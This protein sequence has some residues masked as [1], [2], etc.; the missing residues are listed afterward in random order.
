MAAEG[1][2]IALHGYNH[3]YIS[4]KGLDGLNPLWS[5]SEFAG[6][7]LGIQNRRFRMV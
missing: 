1:L 4:D 7:S 2:C 6:V 5:R 3:C